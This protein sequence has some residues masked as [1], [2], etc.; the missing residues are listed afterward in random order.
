MRILPTR[1]SRENDFNALHKNGRCQHRK[2]EH[3]FDK[4]LNSLLLPWP[5]PQWITVTNRPNETYSITCLR[6]VPL[7][8]CCPQRHNCHPLKRNACTAQI[9]DSMC[10]VSVTR[11]TCAISLV[12][13]VKHRT[14]NGQLQTLSTTM[15]KNN[16]TKESFAT[17]NV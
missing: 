11:P 6:T 1:T 3:V 14:Y 4:L 9:A 13:I 12:V 2:S 15:K 8:P 16:G 7:W 17:D 5:P 10:R